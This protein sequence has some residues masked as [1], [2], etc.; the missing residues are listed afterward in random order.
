M[1]C[2]HRRHA[3]DPTTFGVPTVREPDGLA[4]SSRNSRLGADDRQAAVCV[5]Q[6]LRL[7]EGAVGDGEREATRLVALATEWIAAEPRAKL[8]YVEIVDPV[9][10]DPLTLLEGPATIVAAVWFGDVRLIDNL[11]LLE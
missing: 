6:A 4:I 5:V 1:Q 9:T 3:S 7:V 11:P 8:D 10:L 2:A